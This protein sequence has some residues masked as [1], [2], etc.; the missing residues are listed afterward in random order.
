MKTRDVLLYNEE[1]RLCVA[2]D[3]EEDVLL[4]SDLG[5]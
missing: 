4:Y 2:F 1:K 5:F 3:G